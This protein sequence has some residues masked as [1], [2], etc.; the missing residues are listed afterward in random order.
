[1]Y[2]LFNSS[3]NCIFSSANSLGVILYDRREMGAIPGY[4][5]IVNSTSRSRGMSGKSFRKTSG[6][7][8]VIGMSSRFWATVWCA[9]TSGAGFDASYKVTLPCSG[10]S[11]CTTR[12][13]VSSNARCLLIQLISKITSIPYP[14]R[15]IKYVLYILPF[16]LRGGFT[17][18]CLVTICPPGVL[19]I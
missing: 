6:N 17:T 18:T 12:A 11:K 2:P 14:S 16:K 9:D 5:S 10:E 8:Q 19:I 1:M 7:S 4:N 3:F 13:A 15:M